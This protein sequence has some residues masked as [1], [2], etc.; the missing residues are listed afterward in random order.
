MGTGAAGTTP[1]AFSFK[2]AD[3][4]TATAASG[5]GITASTIDTGFGNPV[6]SWATRGYANSAT[7]TLTNNDYT[8]FAVNSTNYNTLTF[9]FDVRRDAGL[10][11]P[12]SL[13]LYSSTDGVTFT[14][15]GSVITPS[16]T[17][18]NNVAQAFPGPSNP[19]GVTYFRIYGY[20]AA[21]N[22]VSALL[23]LDNVTIGGC[24]TTPPPTITKSFSPNPVAV[25][26]VS[27]LTFVV[28]HPGSATA[29]N[30]SFADALPAGVVVAPVPAI[31]GTCVGT[32]SALPGRLEHQ[33]FRCKHRGGSE[34]HRDC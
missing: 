7:L 26:G 2:A 31:G 30:V 34:L 19:S 20:N 24:Q 28:A 4:A 23:Y 11:G 9:A 10:N 6:N 25:G 5:A 29:N 33:R 15:Y 12:A 3:V 14:P 13:A 27:K 8:E 22:G 21:N 32:V 18:F 1:P 16:P 17:A